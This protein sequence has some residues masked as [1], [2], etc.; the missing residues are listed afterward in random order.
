MIDVTVYDGKYRYTFD[1]D[2]ARAFRHGKEWRD[3]TGDGF[4][5]ALAQDLEEARQGRDALAAHVSVLESIINGSDL[6]DRPHVMSAL[7]S[8]P[9]TSLARLIAQ[10]Q[11]EA[12]DMAEARLVLAHDRADPW[13]QLKRMANE[14]RRQ[15]EETPP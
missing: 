2:G 4:I 15:S 3:C 1:K 7:N 8:A 6:T 5:L 11:A 9:E 10:K 14:L 13:S 12:L